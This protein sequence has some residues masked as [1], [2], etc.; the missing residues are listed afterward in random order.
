LR[1][2]AELGVPAFI[3]SS[4]VSGGFGQKLNMSQVESFMQE[5]N[6]PT[7]ITLNNPVSV[8][9]EKLT[10]RSNL[11]STT[12]SQAQVR[13]AVNIVNASTFGMRGS[14]LDCN[15]QANLNN[16]VSGNIPF[17]CLYVT[18][19]SS[20]LDG[21]VFYLADSNGSLSPGLYSQVGNNIYTVNLNQL[22]GSLDFKNSRVYSHAKG[23]NITNTS[24]SSVNFL[25]V[26]A[27][28]GDNSSD[29]F[30]TGASAPTLSSLPS[31]I[32][33]GAVFTD[34][35]GSTLLCKTGNSA[36]YSTVHPA[37]FD[38]NVTR[39]FWWLVTRPSYNSVQIP[40]AKSS[41]G[42]TCTP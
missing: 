41:I 9:L 39:T 23:I 21:N 10:I 12:P 22:A 18:S 11:H 28:N 38:I 24:A 5:Q 30:W 15:T 36:D 16:L 20:S 35:T 7:L 31:N 14:I 8:D 29:I 1:L 2:E 40:G 27:K 3:T 33:Y 26:R 19:N 42:G 6:G 34:T 13:P 25:D 4:I 17:N 32:T 37:Y